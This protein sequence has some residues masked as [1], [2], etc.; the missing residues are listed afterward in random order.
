[1]DTTEEEQQ[2]TCD[3]YDIDDFTCLD[4]GKDMTE[5]MMAKAYDSVKDRNYE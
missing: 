5:D 4:C 3:H 2:S 1:M